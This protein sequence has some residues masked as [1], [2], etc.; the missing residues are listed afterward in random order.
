[1][2]YRQEKKQEGRKCLAF[3]PC[4]I[5][6]Q[7]RSS[8]SSALLYPPPDKPIVSFSFLEMGGLKFKVKMGSFSKLKRVHDDCEP[9][10]AAPSGSGRF[11]VVKMDGFSM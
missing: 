4:R 5:A 9:N 10:P 1:L 2:G 8:R 6:A 3:L 11:F 7:R